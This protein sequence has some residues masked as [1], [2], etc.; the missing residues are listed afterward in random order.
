MKMIIK[1][2][3][4]VTIFILIGC[5]GNSSSTNQPDNNNTTS[6]TLEGKA[7][8]G[9]LSKATIKLYKLAGVERKLLATE[10]TTVGDTID[11]IGNFNL[12]LEK[13]DD[14]VFYLYQ[15]EGG[16]DYDVDDNGVIDDVATK[17]RGTFHL[18]V[19]GRH[20]K[21]IK[22]ANITAISEIVY[23]KVK[24]NLNVDN[25]QLE[26]K[27]ELL[28]KEIIQNDINEDG[29]IGVEDLLKYNPILDKEKLSTPYQNKI[30]KVIDAILN[31][32][33]LDLDAPI[34][35]DINETI[36]LNENVTLVQKIKIDDASD[37]TVRLMSID[38]DKF[39]YNSNTQELSFLEKNDFEAPIDNNR[40]NIFELTIEATDSYF[41]QTKKLLSIKIIDVN[42]TLPQTPT[43]KDTELSI[44]ENNATD[45]FI[46]TVTVLN[47]GTQSIEK[48]ELTGEDADA[49][50]IDKEGKVF[51]KRSFNYEEK[52]EYTLI[53]KATNGVGSS[54]NIQVTIAIE[55][56]PDIRPKIEDITLKVLEN[57]PIGAIIGEINISNQGDSNISSI[58]LVGN[59]Y[60]DLVFNLKKEVKIMIYLDYELSQKHSFQYMATNEAGESNIANLII[61]VKNIFEYIGSDYPLTEDG[62]QHALDNGD[63]SFVLD[64]LLN[65]R[66]NY[67]NMGN[68]NV[69]SNIAG[70]YVGKSGY[71]VYDISGAMNRGNGS[72]F[73]NFVND[74]TKNN[75][76]VST[77]NQL[78]QADNYYTQI[79]QGIDCT[80]SS[81]LNVTQKDACYNLGLVRL[82]SLTNSVK[83]LFGGDSDTVQKW[84]KGVDVNSSDDLNGNGVLDTSE[85]SAC[86]VVY[87]NN[88]NDNCKNGTIYSYRGGVQFTSGSRTYKLTMIEVDVGSISNGYHNFFQFI[89]SNPNNNTPIL[90][91]GVCNK[92][93]NRTTQHPIDG[94]NYF[95]CPTLNSNGNIMGIKEQ[96][97]GVADIQSLF[98]GGKTKTTVEGYLTNITGSSDGTIGLDNL[99]TYLRT[100]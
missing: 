48:F 28:T 85:A 37:L 34:F 40:D 71:T 62:V 44:F 25:K 43:L 79:V 8:L 17:N 58:E 42:E 84:A 39:N 92:T 45:A 77:I 75:N 27:I 14:E 86:A 66:N 69:N 73:N 55:D 82:T 87:A 90:T 4:I 94:I 53:V 21:S 91:S 16:E 12:H 36:E 35:Q 3:L 68:D 54:S 10:L 83:L 31:D 52:K 18:L 74:I 80:N 20:I 59:N 57:R 26:T 65:N 47:Q 23:Q 72:G 63:Y 93:F 96:I 2:Y 98:S 81:T 46:G 11:T 1:L 61:D 7:Q 67:P 5:G 99:S 32:R 64:E 15:V 78:R 9:V 76:P 70:A 60:G 88:P 95:P 100:H 6:H 38:A 30:S 24:D 56:I 97:E 29:F 13:L 41:N 49:F 19:L 50:T 89:S 51:A 22:Q 33:S